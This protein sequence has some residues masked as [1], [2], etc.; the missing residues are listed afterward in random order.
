MRG[1]GGGSRRCPPGEVTRRHPGPPRRRV[2]GTVRRAARRRWGR[3]AAPTPG[4]APGDRGCHGRTG[5]PWCLPVPARS[6]CRNPAR[7]PPAG[8]HPAARRPRRP[9]RHARRRSRSACGCPPA[10]RRPVPAGAPPPG[11][12]RRTSARSPRPPGSP[13][14]PG[15]ESAGP[16]AE[17]PPRVPRG[18]PPAWPHRPAEPAGWC[19]VPRTRRSSNGRIRGWTGPGSSRG[20]AAVSGCRGRG[21]HH[22][23]PVSLRWA[24]FKGPHLSDHRMAQGPSRRLDL[25][26]V[27]KESR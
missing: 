22:R 25:D 5:G 1:A 3:P 9:G 6:W 10:T 24:Q 20:R 16:P 13:G 2:P 27:T 26:S 12:R 23:G 19:R 17:G 11:P 15:P 18:A 4:R 7:P 8:R 14:R 21:A